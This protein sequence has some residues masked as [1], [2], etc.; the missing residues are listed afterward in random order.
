MKTMQIQ[1]SRFLSGGTGTFPSDLAAESYFPGL[2]Y[3]V[4]SVKAP[5][6]SGL[7]LQPLSLKTAVF[8]LHP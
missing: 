5:D 8:A 7:P 1:S 2:T 3:N 6:F 4:P